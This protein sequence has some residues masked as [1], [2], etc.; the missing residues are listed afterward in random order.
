MPHWPA[1]PVWTIF[2][3]RAGIAL[4]TV[5]LIVLTFVRTITN[6]A[7]CPLPICLLLFSTALV[8]TI[9]GDVSHSVWIY[10]PAFLH[11][12]QAVAS[13]L[14]S[15]KLEL[16]RALNLQATLSFLFPSFL[17]GVIIMFLSVPLLSMV[18]NPHLA[19]PAI[20]LVASALHFVCDFV[21]TKS[22]RA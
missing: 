9:N 11:G 6:R 19:Y 20:V 4:S 22:E 15:R 17:L 7:A 12:T 18:S 13:A 10:V 16:G 8:F 21:V 3:C 5:A 14:H 2:L 1:L